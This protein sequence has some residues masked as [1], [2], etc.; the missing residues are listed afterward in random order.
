VAEYYL[1]KDNEYWISG[2]FETRE[3]AIRLGPTELDLQPGDVFWS[4][5]AQYETGCGY[6]P[7]AD[8]IIDNAIESAYD[9]V[10][11]LSEVWLENLTE[12]VEQDLQRRLNHVWR[13]WLVT[14]KLQPKWW[15]AGFIEKHE[16]P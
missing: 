12:E 11:E 9:D 15:T 16:V 7:S 3:E 1:S 2:P 14:H 6:G 10:D 4:C 5:E 13:E 8:R